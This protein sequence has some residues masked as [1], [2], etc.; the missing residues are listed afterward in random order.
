MLLLSLVLE[1]TAEDLSF[2]PLGGSWCVLGRNLVCFCPLIVD[3]MWNGG[4]HKQKYMATEKTA[5]IQEI[6]FLQ[7]QSHLCWHLSF[8]IEWM[9][10][11]LN[12][13]SH[14]WK[15]VYFCSLILYRSSLERG[16]H[17]PQFISLRGHIQEMFYMTLKSPMFYAVSL[18]ID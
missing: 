4:R 17:K 10:R 9:D 18:V 5:N 14:G 16:R 15:L 13:P 11:R 3:L 2:P 6:T 1:W 8:I 7:H 12:L